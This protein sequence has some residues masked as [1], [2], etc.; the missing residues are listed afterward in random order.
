[1][2]LPALPETSIL[3][4]LVTATDP[5]RRRQL[6]RSALELVEVEGYHRPIPR[7]FL[8]LPKAGEDD[9]SVSWDIAARVLASDT[10]Y[11][12]DAADKEKLSK[13]VG[14]K[15]TVHQ[16]ATKALTAADIEDTPTRG[17]GA[18]LVLSISVADNP[19]QT[20]AFTGSP[21]IITPLL[22]AYARGELPITGTV[23]EVGRAKGKRSAPLAFVVERPF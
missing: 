6:A 13:L 23:I 2:T 19:D 22:Y 18:Y 5:A 1:V 9:E 17:I 14:R 11:D 16:L 15:V 8:D 20:V 3:R 7:A 4:Q 12:P 21:R 10:P